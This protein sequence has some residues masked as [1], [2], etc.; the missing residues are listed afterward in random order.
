[1][2]I[3]EAERVESGLKPNPVLTVSGENF[4]L[5]L[6]PKGFEFGSR[7]DWFA[8][9]TQTFETGAKRNLRVSLAE[10]NLEAAQGEAS[11][12]ERRVVFEVKA[13]YQRVASAQLRVEL[14]RE[15]HT[16]LDQIA[17]LNEVREADWNCA[18]SYWKARARDCD[19]C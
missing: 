8:V 2:A 15:H 13:A 1:V 3:A 4:P 12:V 6:T 9:Y 5:G 16:S 17:G 18:R 11:A 14:L 19:P 10:R 7:T